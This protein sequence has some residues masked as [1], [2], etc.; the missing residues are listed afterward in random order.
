MLGLCGDP[1]RE[2]PTCLL[3]SVGS[4]T[5]CS[6]YTAFAHSMEVKRAAVTIPHVFFEGSCSAV[7]ARLEFQGFGFRF[8]R[9]CKLAGG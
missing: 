7:H 8:L 5:P 4:F 1:F 2:S 9:S 6:I 3:G